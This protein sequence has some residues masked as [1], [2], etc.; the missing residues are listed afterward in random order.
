MESTPASPRGRPAVEVTSDDITVLHYSCHPSRLDFPVP[1][2]TT[3][4]GS[5]PDN[6]NRPGLP[7]TGVQHP[8]SALCFPFSLTVR[9]LTF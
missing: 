6:V 4:W 1:W 5:G 3:N 2:E 8:S 9:R 7:G